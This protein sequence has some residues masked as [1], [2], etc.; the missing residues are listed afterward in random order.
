VHGAILALDPYASP[1]RGTS[2]TD[3]GVHAE[4]QLAA[5]DARLAIPARGWV[6]ALNQHLPD[7]ACVRRARPC[8]R[9]QPALSRQ[10]EALPLPHPPRP[11]A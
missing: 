7:D 10:E 6:L 2:R 1:P 5:F 8:R 11:R 4:G 3:S 9:L